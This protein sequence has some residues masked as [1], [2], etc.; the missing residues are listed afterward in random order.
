MLD[1]SFTSAKLKKLIKEKKTYLKTVQNEFASKKL[2]E[3]ILFLEKD[4]LPLVLSQSTILYWEIMRHITQKIRQAAE[5]KCDAIMCL[6]PFHDRMPDP[7]IIGI[8]NPKTQ[9]LT[10]ITFDEIEV[11]VDRIGANGKTCEPVNLPLYEL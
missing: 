10:D 4:V 7:Y 3:E 9:S 11:T 1:D 8:D 6:I 5:L 2:Q